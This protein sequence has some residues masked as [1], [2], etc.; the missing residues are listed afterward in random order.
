LE[1]GCPQW[2]RE[3]RYELLKAENELDALKIITEH[4]WTFLME[5]VTSLTVANKALAG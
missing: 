2:Y 1:R 4:F 5:Q 3:Q